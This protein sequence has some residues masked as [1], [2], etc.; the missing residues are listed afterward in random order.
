MV[1]GHSLTI[2]FMAEGR[3]TVSVDGGPVS[4]TFGTQAEAWEAGVGTA[5]V[6][7][8]LHPVPVPVGRA[9]PAT[10]V[11]RSLLASRPG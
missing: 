5:T 2:A 4:G 6:Q 3:W 11:V 7:D 8:Q 10:G 9:P 1:L